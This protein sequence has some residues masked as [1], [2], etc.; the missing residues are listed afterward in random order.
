MAGLRK[1]IY[2]EIF[3]HFY[4]NNRRVVGQL[5][6]EWNGTKSTEVE[7]K[8]KDLETLWLKRFSNHAQEWVLVSTPMQEELSSLLTEEVLSNF[9]KKRKRKS[10]F[11]LVPRLSKSVSDPIWYKIARLLLLNHI[12]EIINFP[13]MLRCKKE[14][15]NL[16]LR[17]VSSKEI[18]EL[19]S[20]MQLP[21]LQIIAQSD[22]P[23]HRSVVKTYVNSPAFR[24]GRNDRYSLAKKISSLISV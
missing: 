10:S 9:G 15:L 8:Q 20:Y 2:A 6:R 5:R 14:A 7:L 13:D 12:S 17:I 11:R 3:C 1:E 22:N 19:S 4:L 18:Q 24:Q 16:A 23:R 21:V